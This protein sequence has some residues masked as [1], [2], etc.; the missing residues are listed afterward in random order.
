MPAQTFL[1]HLES[2]SDRSRH[3]VDRPQ[4]V[5]GGRP[6]LARYDLAAAARALAPADLAGRPPTL[7][8]YRELL[9]LPFDEAPVTLGEGMTPLLHCPRLGAALG[10]ADLWI[11]DE[12]QLPTGSFKARGMAVAVSMARHYGLRRLAAP[13][14]GNAGGALAAYAARAGIDCYVFLPRDTPIVNRIE[15]AAHGAKTFL[16]DGLIHDC[17]ALVRAGAERFGWFDVSTLREPWRLEG[18]KTMGYEL[19]E[20]L[21]W[22]LPDVILY[23]TGGGTGLIGMDK[24][25]AE[26]AA[27]GWLGDARRPRFYACQ[28][29]GCAPLP[30][31]FDAGAA[32]GIAPPAPATVAAG[33]RVPKALGDFLILD[34]V[35][36]SGGAARAADESRLLARTR[37]AA[38]REGIALCPE[39]AACLDVLATSLA[40][41]EIRPE[42]RILLFNT[43]A[44]QKHVEALA[45]E[46]PELR[47]D[48]PDWDLVARA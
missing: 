42:E 33:L 43:G 7:W 30:A 24:A 9:P 44:L 2:T 4:S 10:V 6:L 48:A 18:K 21:G 13:S 22:R 36:R 3:P 29:S 27:L 23:P 45:V 41:G 46:L 39:A 5:H 16:V 31:A 20:Q 47:K 14:A 34:A 38:R 37:D 35:R 8:R 1:T 11:K 40:R 26:M 15:V 32:H 12:S 28:S 17:A 19:A 25:F